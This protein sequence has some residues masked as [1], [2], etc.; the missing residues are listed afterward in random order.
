MLVA[1][2]G[3][4][5]AQGTCDP[6]SPW[7]NPNQP[8]SQRVAELMSQMSLDQ[9]DFLV[10]GHGTANEPPSLPPANQYGQ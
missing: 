10:E 9:K 8:V 7:L 1:L 4:A 3:T 6:S 5:A 2:P